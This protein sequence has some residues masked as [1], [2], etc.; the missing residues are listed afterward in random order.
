MQNGLMRKTGRLGVATAWMAGVLIA[1]SLAG[2]GCSGKSGDRA[3]A[4]ARPG[5]SVPVRTERLRYPEARLVDHVDVYHGVE[6]ADPYRWLE[7]PESEESRAWIAAQQA[8]TQPWLE[9]IPARQRIQDRMTEIWNYERFGIPVKEGGR[10]FFTRNDGLQN[11][12][13]LFYA[14]RLGDEPTLL[15]DPN[16]FSEDG[17]ISMASWSVSPDGRYLAYSISDGGSDWRTWRVRDIA[18]GADLDDVIEWSKFSGAAWAADSSGFYYSAYDAPES[19]QEL[20]ASNDNQKIYFH[21]L[22][23][24]Q[25]QNELVYARPDQP[26]WG[27]N[28]WVTEDGRFLVVYARMGTDRRNGLFVRDLES[29]ATEFTEIVLPGEASFSVFGNDGATLFVQTDLDAPLGR[30]IAIDGTRPAREGWRELVPESRDT[31][32]SASHVGGRFVLQYLKDARASVRVHGTDGRR[33]RE[34]RLPGIGSVGGFGGKA[35]DNETFFT[36]SSF[37]NPGTIYRYDV[38]TNETETF[39][40]PKVGFDPGEYVTHQVFYRSKDGTRVPMF[41]THKRGLPLDRNRPTLLYGYGGF[42]IPVTPS[43]S[44]ANMAWL[45]MGGIYAVANIRGGSEY[46]SEWHRQGSLL[47]KQNTFD[48][49]IAAAEDLIRRGYTQPSRLGIFGG[50]NGGLL[51]AACMIQR[52]ELFGA[53]IPAVGVLDMLRFDQFT[54]GWAWR[55]DYGHPEESEADFRYNLAYSP[56][57][58]IEPGRCYPATLITTADRDDR[59]VP[60]HS[61]KFGAALQ[62]A[63]GCDNPILMRIETRAGHGAGTPTSKLIEAAAD[64]WAFLYRVLGMEQDE[65]VAGR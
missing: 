28:A 3:G 10:Y 17:T 65:G 23:Q 49:F 56:Y 57:H 32:R 63:Q 35:D 14:E 58:N 20:V 39:R 19:G 51:V 47:N 21:R 26:R 52:P 30:V 36:F 62:A 7:D 4:S 37:T 24:D 61:F 5:A 22:G 8:V 31:L 12:S 18:R 33:L 40:Q 29:E 34:I 13:V 6:V 43:F 50:S 42:M 45:E 11:Q 60:M 41:I 9:S 44:P 1:G 55:S 53:V 64:R 27:L 38:D 16:T 59:V 25:S 15:I 46:G 54:I 48:D 2:T